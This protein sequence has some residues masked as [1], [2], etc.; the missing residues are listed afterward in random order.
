[1]NAIAT[2]A[3]LPDALLDPAAFPRL[4]ASVE[5]RE[6]HI[7]WVF[8]A[9]NRAYKVKKPVSFPFLDYG[10]LARRRAENFDR[11]VRRLVDGRLR[12]DIWE[13]LGLSE[14]L[15]ARIGRGGPL[16]AWAL[17][18][19]ILATYRNRRPPEGTP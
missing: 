12:H 9:G 5:L 6:T 13:T 16:S 4:P 1:M 7:S 2:T 3:V 19:E 17:A 8:L 14:A 15:A 18:D 10:S 11:R